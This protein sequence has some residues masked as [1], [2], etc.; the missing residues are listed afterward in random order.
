MLTGISGSVPTLELMRKQQT[1]RG[2][3][4]SS[5]EHQRDMVRAL[6][7]FDWRPVID[8]RYPLEQIAEAFAHQIS[9]SHFGKI[10]LQY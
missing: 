8:S 4:V 9:A 5:R 7:N 2:L 1:L 3:I 10:C 6:E